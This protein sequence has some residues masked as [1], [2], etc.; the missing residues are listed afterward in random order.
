MSCVPARSQALCCICLSICS[1][2]IRRCRPCNGIKENYVMQLLQPTVL[3][4]SRMNSN[5]SFVRFTISPRATQ[6]KQSSAT[7]ASSWK[8]MLHTAVAC[9]CTRRRTGPSAPS[10]SPSTLMLILLRLGSLHNNNRVHARTS[11]SRQCG[12][13][14]NIPGVLL[15]DLT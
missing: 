14:L 8:L 7:L 5:C 6:V 11:H 1:T 15:L 9:C 2:G 12:S 13:H 3:H 10:V 4:T